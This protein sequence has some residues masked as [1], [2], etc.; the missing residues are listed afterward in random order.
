MQTGPGTAIA[1]RLRTELRSRLRSWVWVGL[2]V[3]LAGGVT[4]AAAAGARRTETAVPR[5]AEASN[6]SDLTISQFG[7]SG[8]DYGRLAKLPQVSYAYRAD[9]FYFTGKTDR[10][11][12]LDVGKAGLIAAA[13]PSVGVAR[14]APKIVRGRR[15]RQDRRDEAVPDEE[16]ARLLGLKVGSTFAARFATPA[17]LED[18][19][20]YNDDPTKFPVR[21]PRATFKVVGISAAFSTA[22]SNYP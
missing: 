4:I 20:A 2:L 12:K 6:F 19:L 22:S 8:I 9:N 13:D 17:Q 5:S 15:A 18:F 1:F 10:G 11:R 7:H 21:G 16:A 3:G 14:D